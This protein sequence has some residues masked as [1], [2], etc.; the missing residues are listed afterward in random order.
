LHELNARRSAE[1]FYDEWVRKSFSALR[2]LRP[3]RWARA[4]RADTGG[5]PPAALNQQ[6]IALRQQGEFAKAREAYEAALA[7]DASYATACLNLG[8]L[9]D[10]YLGQPAE[11]LAMYS[12]YL[13]LTPAGDTAVGKWVADLKNRV[14]APAP[15]AAPPAPASKES[16]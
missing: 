13:A 4:E 3:G 15:A 1:G 10:L 14:P 8:I 9:H 7:A 2:E 16:S 11:A 12:R 5:S 6:A